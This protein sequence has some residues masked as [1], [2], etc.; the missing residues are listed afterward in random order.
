MG[1]GNITLEEKEIDIINNS[2]PNH[3]YQTDFGGGKYFNVV[4]ED[5]TQAEIELTS[6]TKISIT[7][8]KELNAVKGLKITKVIG[9]K[10]NGEIN[11][12]AFDLNQLVAF[13]SFLSKLDLGEISERRIK[14]TD[15]A[16]DPTDEATKNKIELLLQTA[17][18]IELIEKLLTSG[19]I[20]SKD[21]V[22]I[23]YRKEQLSIFKKILNDTEYWRQYADQ[24]NITTEKEEK[25]LQHFFKHNEWIFGYGLDYRF[26]SILQDE[27][28]LS[29]T[30]L[31]GS[32]SVITDF[33]LGDKFFTTFVEIKKPTTKLFGSKRN[34]SNAWKLS[35]DFLDS[36]SQILEQKASGLINFESQQ[37]NSSGQIITQKPYDSKV[38]LIIGSWKQLDESTSDFDKEIKKKTFE[39]YR[40]DSRNIEILTYDELYERAK[41]IVE[42]Q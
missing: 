36:V 31:D 14:L 11:I 9:N 26:N 35:T 30:E 15:D 3:L 23:G 1:V 7:Y 27:A 34:R 20:E 22:N 8:I 2:K 32:N 21:L 13:V 19:N 37:Y 42:G 6:K 29:G 24:K 17:E 40:R 5:D 18:G 25:V 33:L 16:F 41:F 28:H 10:K 4:F 39:L 12:S 38:I